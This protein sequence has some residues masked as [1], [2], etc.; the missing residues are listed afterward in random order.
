MI[1]VSVLLTIIAESLITLVL[2]VCHEPSTRYATTLSFA[3]VNFL[4]SALLVVVV[5]CAV[6]KI[7]VAFGE[8]IRT[9]ENAY[10]V[11]A[12]QSLHAWSQT[13]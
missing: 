12:M 3:E 4:F 1:H 9:S 11:L 2:S 6:F 5:T 8:G 7:P 10:G 13:A